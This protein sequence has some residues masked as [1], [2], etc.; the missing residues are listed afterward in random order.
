M[1]VRDQL[2]KENKLANCLIL[3]VSLFPKQTIVLKKR[4]GG[5]PCST[6][7]VLFRTQSSIYLAL[8][9]VFSSIHL[10]NFKSVLN[11]VKQSD[12]HSREN[13]LVLLCDLGQRPLE[14]HQ[15]HDWKSHIAP[16]VYAYNCTRH[17]STGM[18]PF[19]LMFGRDP[20]LPVD[21]AFGLDSNQTQKVPLTKYMDSLKARLKHSFELP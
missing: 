4:G 8:S 10:V 3:F 6:H 11:N 18:S 20:L 14:P 7:K 2:G 19:S 9:S 13:Q 1:Y 15:K 12:G 16:L 5:N 17:E 21:W